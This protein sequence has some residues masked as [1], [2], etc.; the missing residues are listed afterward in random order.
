MGPGSRVTAPGPA[1]LLGTIGYS[2]NFQLIYGPFEA[3]PLRSSPLFVELCVER[4][5]RCHLASQLSRITKSDKINSTKRPKTLS[6]KV[7]QCKALHR[8]W[9][10]HRPH[11]H[12]DG[13]I[14]GR[15]LHYVLSRLNSKPP[16]KPVIPE[17]TE[18]IPLHNSND[19]QGKLKLS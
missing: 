9:V 16:F 14:A 8:G 19:A 1:G 4:C 2:T 17:P 3:E 12:R 13:P 6:R 18:G 11:R 7:D 10:R 5:H 15:A